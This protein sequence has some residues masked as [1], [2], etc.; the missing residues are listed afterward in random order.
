MYATMNHT[1]LIVDDSRLARMAAARALSALYPHW[2]RLEA[3][4]AEEA[5][6]SIQQTAID[7]VLVDFNMPGQNGLDL[8][9]ELRRLN[10]SLPVAVISANRQKEIVGRAAEIGAVFLPKPLTQ[11]ALAHFLE[12]AVHD[13]KKRVP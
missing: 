10:P 5:V 2:T 13:L 8:A 9:V 11:D 4:S 12:G 1:V 7:V 6:R 3:S